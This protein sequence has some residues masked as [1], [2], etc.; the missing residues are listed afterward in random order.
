LCKEDKEKE[1]NLQEQISRI[2][3]M[4]GLINENIPQPGESS[5]KPISDEEKGGMEKQTEQLTVTEIIGMLDYIPYYKEVLQDIKNDDYSWGVT[6]K[7]ME[8]AKYLKNNPESIYN[9]PP[10]IIVNGKLQ[11]GAH[12]LSALYLLQNHLDSNNPL[13]GDTKLNVEFYN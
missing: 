13:W 2:Q 8:Y 3:S 11:D 12:R 4:M 9:L 7:V 1:M 5:G 6:E 10:I